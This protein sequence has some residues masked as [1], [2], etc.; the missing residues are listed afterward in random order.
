MAGSS[1]CTPITYGKFTV[2][3][4]PTVPTVDIVEKVLSPTSFFAVPWGQQPLP[5]CDEKLA[6]IVRLPP[7]GRRLR[8][9][10]SETIKYRKPSIVFGRFS[11][12]NRALGRWGN[13]T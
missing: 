4:V 2:P 12:K 6:G 8:R 7:R 1:V 9:C 3:T 11:L 5:K 10:S 13:G